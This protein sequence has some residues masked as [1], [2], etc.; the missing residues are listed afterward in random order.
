[1]GSIKKKANKN[2]Y[3]INK[4]V[5]NS[6]TKTTSISKKNGNKNP[7]PNDFHTKMPPKHTKTEVKNKNTY[8]LNMIE[9]LICQTKA[10]EIISSYTT[11]SMLKKA[12]IKWIFSKPMARKKLLEIIKTQTFNSSVISKHIK[13]WD[14]KTINT[15]KQIEKIGVDPNIIV[16]EMTYEHNIGNIFINTEIQK[17]LIKTIKDPKILVK[18]M[19]D[20]IKGA[21]ILELLGYNNDILHLIQFFKYLH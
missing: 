18:Y 19:Q 3:L 11:K 10:P 20:P 16:S 15:A 1:M 4:Y 5:V 21:E 6:M 14:L 2:S 13:M 9:L 7:V 8:N 17:I 12:Y